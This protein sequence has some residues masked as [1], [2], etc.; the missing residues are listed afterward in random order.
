[1]T[2]PNILF[3]MTDQQR[4]D[5]IA[6]LGNGNIHTPNMDRLVRRG[7]SLYPGLLDLSGLRSGAGDHPYGMRSTHDPHFQQQPFHSRSGTGRNARRPLRGLSRPHPVGT[8]LPHLRCGEVPLGSVGRGHRLCV[9][10]T[11]RRALQQSGAT[12][13]GRL[14][15]M[16]RP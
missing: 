9:P 15:G 5:T 11:Q 10:A 3:I 1:M 8:G 2:Q 4:F 7:V 13:G 14:R 16:D 6:A 12:E